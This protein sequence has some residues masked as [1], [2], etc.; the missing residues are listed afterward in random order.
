M[1][2]KLAR[3]SFAYWLSGALL[4]PEP[5]PVA[6]AFQEHNLTAFRDNEIKTSEIEI[7][8]FH[9]LMQAS[10]QFGAFDRRVL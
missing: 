7:E 1:S 10:G 5:L 8:C 9:V 2:K 6:V 3:N 4:N